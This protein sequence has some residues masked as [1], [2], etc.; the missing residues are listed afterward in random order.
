[1]TVPLTLLALAIRSSAPEPVVWTKLADPDPNYIAPKP[2]RSVKARRRRV[3][4]PAAPSTM[5]SALI[6][7]AQAAREADER[8]RRE[9]ENRVRAAEE[10]ER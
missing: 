9:Y 3:Q 2:S 1:M 8:A 6:N 5:A 7:L 4:A 10:A